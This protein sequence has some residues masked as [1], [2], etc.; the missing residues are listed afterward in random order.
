[1][2][3]SVRVDAAGRPETVEIQVSSGFAA[4]DDAAVAAVKRWEF[5]P[6]R[7]GGEP[8]PSRVEVPIQ[9][10]LDRP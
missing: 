4:L 6:G 2:L 8:V 9:F 3:L 7:L 10:Q 5:E 1:M